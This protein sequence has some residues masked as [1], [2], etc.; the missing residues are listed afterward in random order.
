MRVRQAKVLL[1]ASQAHG[2]VANTG[3]VPLVALVSTARTCPFVPNAL[4]AALDL[5]TFCL[6]SPQL[7][8]G[9]ARETVMP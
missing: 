9:S 5:T 3:P 7:L 1:T 4:D 8:R 2:A 6:W